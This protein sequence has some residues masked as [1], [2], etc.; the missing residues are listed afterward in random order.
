MMYLCLSSQFSEFPWKLT[1]L[2][3]HCHNADA[4]QNLLHLSSDVIG[5]Y[6]IC[7]AA[8]HDC[9]VKQGV[10]QLR[11]PEEAQTT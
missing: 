5:L 2:S 1:E 7:C 8:L 9:M 11:K 3:F 10:R 6:C 4:M